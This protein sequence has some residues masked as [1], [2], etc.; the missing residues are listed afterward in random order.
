M[1]RP[2]NVSPSSGAFLAIWNDIE[3]SRVQEYECW[4]AIEHVPERVWV[5][6]FAGA[7]RYVAASGSM[8]KYFTLYQ[9]DSLDCLNSAQYRDLVDS[10]TPW[11]ASMRPSFRNFLRKT[12]TSDVNMGVVLGT[13]L[14]VFRVLWD[15]E[16]TKKPTPAQLEILAQELLRQGAK[17][18]VT[19]VQIGFSTPAG[20][21]A[22]AN[23]DIAPSGVEHIFFLHTAS[24]DCLHLLGKLFA[25]VAGELLN[26][27]LWHQSAAYQFSSLVLNTN[28]AQ[29]S[30]PAARLDLMVDCV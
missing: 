23:T 3:P 18:C 27:S 19:Q 5:T 2:I 15:A 28:V 14:Q 22:I 24:F 11:S 20:P 7:A 13:G 1:N 12:Y 29:I 6:G 16:D 25:D 17:V 4:H 21:Q 26:S 8:P 10:P 9:L 30:R